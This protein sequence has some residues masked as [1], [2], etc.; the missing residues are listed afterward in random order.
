[1][2]NKRRKG[3]EA[4]HPYLRKDKGPK[5]S[6]RKP[7]IPKFVRDTDKEKEMQRQS[8]GKYKWRKTTGDD[9]LLQIF[10]D[11]VRE[12]Y[13]GDEEKTFQHIEQLRKA[14]A[15]EQISK[16]D[17]FNLREMIKDRK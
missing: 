3:A 8:L 12:R 13:E 2:T 5:R 16:A 11:S 9:D 6:E 7:Y 1:M 10:I 17:K 4:N 15:L 14:G